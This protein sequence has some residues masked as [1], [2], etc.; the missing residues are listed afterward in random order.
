MPAERLKCVNA[1]NGRNSLAEKRKQPTI[2]ISEHVGN[3]LIIFGHVSEGC[4]RDSLLNGAVAR[5]GLQSCGLASQDVAQIRSERIGD[6]REVI[7]RRTQSGSVLRDARGTLDG[8]AEALRNILRI[9][10]TK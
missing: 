6:T 1:A 2:R 3:L 8:Q 5:H 4:P 9:T 10:R 7:G